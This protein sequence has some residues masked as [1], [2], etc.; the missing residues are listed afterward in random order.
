MIVT[1][2]LWRS[3]IA[4]LHK[5]ID[6]LILSVLK[7]PKRGKFGLPVVWYGLASSAPVDATFY[8]W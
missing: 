8:V 1:T 5:L 3:L 7:N 6:W 2:L 4:S